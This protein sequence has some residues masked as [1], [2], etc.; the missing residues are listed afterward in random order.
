[1]AGCLMH[2]KEH[3]IVGRLDALGLTATILRD[4]VDEGV[5]PV[6]ACT[7]NDPEQLPGILGWGKVTRALRD[8]LVS[9]PFNWTR[10]NHRGQPSTVRPGNAVA[11]VVASGTPE[12]GT[13]ER[14]ATRSTKGPATQAAIADNALTFG[15]MDEEFKKLDEVVKKAAP[16][17]SPAQT[18]MLLYFIDEEGEEIRAELSLPDHMDEDGYVDSWRER[19]LLAAIPLDRTPVTLSDEDEDEDHYEAPVSRVN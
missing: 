11:I 3:E 9:Q 16:S 7:K 15:A 18:W 19:I 12:T 6:L 2:V 17:A 4:A 5:A 1:V 13:G 14:P 10:A 8:R